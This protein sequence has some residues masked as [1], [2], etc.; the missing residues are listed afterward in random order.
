VHDEL[1]EVGLFSRELRSA[2]QHTF[3][4]A[5][6]LDDTSLELLKRRVHEEAMLDQFFRG[7]TPLGKKLFALLGQPVPVRRGGAAQKKGRKSTL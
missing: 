3:E 1:T 5:C 7:N 4:R 6:P 2:V